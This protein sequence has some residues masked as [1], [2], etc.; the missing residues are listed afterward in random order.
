M[1]RTILPLG[2]MVAQ[3]P[4]VFLLYPH[5][6]PFTKSVN[7]H[8][9]YMRACGRNMRAVFGPTPMFSPWVGNSS[10]EPTIALEYLPGFCRG[11]FGGCNATAR[12]AHSSTVG[13]GGA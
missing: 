1:C 8:L 11:S 10:E 2:R 9:A 7:Y 12:I 5:T 13:G 6:L 3:S 4:T